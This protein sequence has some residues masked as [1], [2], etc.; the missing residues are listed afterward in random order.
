VAKTNNAADAD[1]PT[2][3][4]IAGISERQVVGAAAGAR[5]AGDRPAACDLEDVVDAALDRANSSAL[6]V[7][8]PIR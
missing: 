2:A 6:K 7:T 4:I 3:N 5:S 8:Q 1:K